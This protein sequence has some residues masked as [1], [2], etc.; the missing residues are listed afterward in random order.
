[1]AEAG[2]GTAILDLKKCVDYQQEN[3]VM[4]WT[5]Y[6][7]CPLKA[8]AIVL[9]NGYMP[10]VTDKCVGCGVCEYVCPVKAISIIPTRRK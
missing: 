10:E 9:K 6:E 3:G 2:M 4:C 5:C 7:R 8:S 1:M